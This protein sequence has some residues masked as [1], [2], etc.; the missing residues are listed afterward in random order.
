MKS[1]PSTPVGT[2][3]ITG[4]YLS[5][6]E[7]CGVARLGSRDVNFTGFYNVIT[8]VALIKFNGIQVL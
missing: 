3:N 4:Q 8:A 6:I 7:E 5:P 2:Q 1:L